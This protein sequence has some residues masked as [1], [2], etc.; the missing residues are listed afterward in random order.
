[1]G[2]MDV[3]LSLLL[4]RE[5]LKTRKSTGCARLSEKRMVAIPRVGFS[6]SRVD[7]KNKPNQKRTND[8][9]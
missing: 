6:D 9:T 8:C 2:E 3:R 5:T 1:M 4:A 7:K